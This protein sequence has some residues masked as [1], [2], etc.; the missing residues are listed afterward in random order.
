[1]HQPLIY[2]KKTNSYKA[3]NPIVNRKTARNGFAQVTK[4]SKNIDIIPIE[5]PFVY[6]SL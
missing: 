3:P 2:K 6:S 5:N 1:M 4:D